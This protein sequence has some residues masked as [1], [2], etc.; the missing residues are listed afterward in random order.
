[1]I[2][3]VTTG[4]ANYVS[5]IRNRIRSRKF[6][7]YGGHSIKP[8]K[9]LFLAS[10]G[11][12]EELIE[13]AEKMPTD[14]PK[15]RF[16]PNLNS[17]AMRIIPGTLIIFDLSFEPAYPYSL[18]NFGDKGWNEAEF[19]STRLKSFVVILETYT[20]RY[21]LSLLNEGE[22]EPI[23]EHQDKYRWAMVTDPLILKDSEFIRDNK[24]PLED[25][26]V[27]VINKSLDWSEIE[28]SSSSV[29]INKVEYGP[30][31][32]FKYIPCHLA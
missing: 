22:E 32:C 23:F 27:S 21:E 3:R 19:L 17:K 24:I 1:M 25:N 30:L 11:K 5:C 29:F 31:R 4:R 18:D 20:Q 9:I 13:M 8:E 2:T 7:N 14:F 28:W 12:L 16:K 6:A 15:Q 26:W 10:L